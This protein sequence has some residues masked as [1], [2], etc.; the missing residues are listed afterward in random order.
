M[1]EGRAA[2]AAGG[3]ALGPGDGARPV[4]WLADYVYGTIATLVAIAG[5]TFETNPGALTTAGVVVVGA[6]AIWLA[7]ALS[8]L[9]TLSS[10]HGLRLNV[11]DVVHDLRGSWS[12]VSAAIP[13]TVIFTLAGIHLWT[14]R[15]A[16][17][18]AE[19][20]GVLALA[21]VGIGTTTGSGRTLLRRALYVGGLVGVGVAIVLFEL[22]VHLL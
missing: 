17:A 2:G 9:V 16:F 11:D 21:V 4:Q 19:V 20:V 1:A 10:W 13:T 5:L 3:D 12:I 14:V 15:T 7:H 18:L 6:V 8:R 22:L